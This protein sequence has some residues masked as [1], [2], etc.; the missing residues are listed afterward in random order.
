VPD[1][2]TRAPA[3]HESPRPAPDVSARRRALTRSLIISAVVVLPLVLVVGIDLDACAA[4]FRKLDARHALALFG[5]YA[6]AALLRGFRLQALLPAGVSL[7]RLVT[8]SFRHQFFATFM[9]FKT[10]EAA[11]PIILKGDGV[12]MSRSIA[13]LV[14]TRALDL[15]ALLTVLSVAYLLTR[16]DLPPE[17][18]GLGSVLLAIWLGATGL[19]AWILIGGKR[20]AA[21]LRARLPRFFDHFGKW[22][23]SAARAVDSII[24]AT[25]EIPLGRVLRGLLISLGVWSALAAYNGVLFD[26]IVGGQPLAVWVV[27]AMFL[28]LGSQIPIQGFAG[29]GTTEAL[30]VVLLAS[31]GIPKEAALAAGVVIH[32]VQILFCGLIGVLGFVAALRVRSRGTGD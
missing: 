25:L 11:L 5:F 17:L 3:D 23:A 1:T 12:P 15:L 2:D 21:S 31:V 30:T 6:S 32:A 9:P 7:P 20:T 26:Q 16:H 14:L 10:G 4:G 18:N 22:G 29:I 28:S 8:V 19:A 27:L 13:V 24:A